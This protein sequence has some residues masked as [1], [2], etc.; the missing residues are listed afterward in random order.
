MHEKKAWI[1]WWSLLRKNEQDETHASRTS[2]KYTCSVN[3][4]SRNSE[5]TIS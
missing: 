5:A 1:I 3:Y 2:T 4:E